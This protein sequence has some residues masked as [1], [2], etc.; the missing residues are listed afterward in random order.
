MKEPKFRAWNMSGGLLES[1][2]NKMT[3][4]D[5]LN[6]E[7]DHLYFVD[8]RHGGY[9]YKQ[10]IIME[11]A[12]LKDRLGKE[13]CQDDI[14]LSRVGYKYKVGKHD[15][16]FWGEPINVGKMGEDYCM[17]LLCHINVLSEIIGNVHENPELLEIEK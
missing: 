6:V 9:F 14:F 2:D 11:Y 7:G 10:T 12:D 1:Y 17:T 16:A 13:Y 15:G 8:D 3:Y 5:L 4:F